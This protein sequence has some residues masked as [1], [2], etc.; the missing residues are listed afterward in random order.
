LSV[1]A[2][3]NE[4]I[5]S[6]AGKSLRLKYRNLW[7]YKVSAKD[8]DSEGKK[9][10]SLGLSR[11][12]RAATSSFEPRR[13]RRRRRRK[14]RALARRPESST[15]APCWMRRRFSASLGRRGFWRAT[16]ASG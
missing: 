5:L 11:S 16:C 3:W 15:T 13:R 10:K 4:Q 12:F 6:E 8:L 7:R 9:T 2:C 14:R 1:V